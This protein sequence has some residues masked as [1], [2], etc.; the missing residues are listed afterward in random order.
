MWLEPVGVGPIA[1]PGMTYTLR[2]QKIR[3]M[4]KRCVLNQIN[5][6]GVGAIVSH[7]STVGNMAQAVR[8]RVLGTVTDGQ[9]NPTHRSTQPFA[10]D[11][12][13]HI[14]RS[15]TRMI[16]DVSPITHSEYCAKYAGSRRRTY[17]NAMRSLE[18]S[19]V[20]LQDSYSNVFLKAEKWPA[21]AVK[22][23]RVVSPRSY[24]YLLAMGVYIHPLEHR[25]YRCF[26]RYCNSP[27]IMKGL[28]QAARAEVACNHWAQFSDPV[29][30]GLD[31]S[32]FDQHTSK[33]AL[34]FEHGFYL[35]P[36][37]NDALLAKLCSWQLRGRCYANLDDGR[38]KWTQ[39]GGRF[40]GD[41]NTAL[42][43]CILSATMLIGYCEEKGIKARYMVDGDDCV[44]FMERADLA[45]FMEGLT[46]WY[47]DRG[48]LMKIEGPYTRLQHIEFCQSKLVVWPGGKMFVRNPF[49]AVTQDH[50]WIQRGGITYAEVM[51]ATGLGG[52]SL[53]GHMPILGAYYRMLAGNRR[54][55][56]KVMAQLDLKSGWMR[57]VSSW[58]G[59]Y[60][61]PSDQLRVAF[62]ETFGVHPSDQKDLEKYYLKVSLHTDLP[63]DPN[64]IKTPDFVEVNTKLSILNG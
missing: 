15:V 17:E 13:L 2:C 58:D 22:A 10:T 34:Q 54:L 61:P 49:K 39:E 20:Q 31:A 27:V 33:K 6:P 48:Y 5:L 43:N 25:L 29:A 53:Y 7:Q 51:T 18:R 9:W 45:R 21:R 16:G 36:Y 37:R 14:R 55:S 41:V 26:R 59:H 62:Y 32:K 8:E 50:T 24:R 47:K 3:L 40:S 11:R 28:D 56:T 35:K 57:S 1:V 23:G 38:L 63:L 42:G 30:V 52:L 46:A 64:Q 44:V 12:M 4:P 19:P 60:S